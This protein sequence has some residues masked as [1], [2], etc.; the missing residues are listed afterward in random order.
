MHWIEQ[1][2]LETQQKKIYLFGAGSR[3]F[4]FF[5]YIAGNEEL[6]NRIEGIIDNSEDKW[7]SFILNKYPIFSPQKLLECNKEELFIVI[8]S[9]HYLE[10]KE[11]LKKDYNFA[12]FFCLDYLV[13]EAYKQWQIDSTYLGE[14]D[15][16]RSFLNDKKSQTIFEKIISNRNNGNFDYSD[17]YEENQYFVADIVTLGT[18][19]VFIDAGAYNGDTIEALIEKTNNCYKKVYTFE[20]GEKS[21]DIIQRKFSNNE[22]IEPYKVGLWRKKDILLFEDNGVE[23]GNKLDAQGNIKVTVDALDNLIVDEAVTFIKMDIEGAELEALEG[24]KNIIVNHKPTL[25]IS[26]YHKY[27]DLWEIPLYIKSLVPEYKLFLRHHSLVNSDTV[28]YATL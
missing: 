19:E 23:L 28:L 26:I 27:D 21:F 4:T 3:V 15:E 11:Q 6:E 8:T 7:G 17:I 24:A 9:G 5:E 14:I 18:E 25:A 2:K 1:L 13:D 10:I 12:S 20:P 16:V 22:K